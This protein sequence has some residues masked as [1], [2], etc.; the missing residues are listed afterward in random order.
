MPEVRRTLKHGQPVGGQVSQGGQVAQHEEKIPTARGMM[1]VSDRMIGD[2]M[3][4][5]TPSL[6][7]IDG[8]MGK[9]VIT[10]A[11]S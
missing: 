8:D 10:Y 3:R 7:I 5:G 9:C 4:L 1:F 2:M 6:L 11:Y